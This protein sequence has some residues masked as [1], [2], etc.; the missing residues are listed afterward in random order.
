MRHLFCHGHRFIEALQQPI[1]AL[2]RL[3]RAVMT[4]SMASRRPRL[5]W[6]SMGMRVGELLAGLRLFSDV[7]LH[8]LV[9]AVEPGLA[10]LGREV[11]ELRR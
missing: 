4:P 10:D 8:Q 1:Y 9:L 11:E 2:Q 7:V 6:V 5:R 3:C